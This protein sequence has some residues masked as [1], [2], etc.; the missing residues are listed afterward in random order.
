MVAP[1]RW[2]SLL[3]LLAEARGGLPR[4]LRPVDLESR[5]SRGKR[6][7]RPKILCK[8]SKRSCHLEVDSRPFWGLGEPLRARTAS[9]RAEMAG[10][11]S[12]VGT[13]QELETSQKGI[14]TAKKDVKRLGL[15][16]R[17][18]SSLKSQERAGKAAIQGEP[19]A[20]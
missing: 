5:T 13:R 10:V 16:E 14:E 19:L 9:L 1:Q 2:R 15:R 8:R 6:N 12:S 11:Q 20:K 4:S 7:V 18:R 3:P 17:K